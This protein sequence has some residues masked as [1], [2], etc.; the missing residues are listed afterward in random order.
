MIQ[1]LLQT[2]RS[3]LW[4]RRALR[5][6]ALSALLYRAVVAAAQDPKPDIAPIYSYHFNTWEYYEHVYRWQADN[7][8]KIKDTVWLPNVADPLDLTVIYDPYA[9]RGTARSL[10]PTATPTPQPTHVQMLPP[11]FERLF[12][13]SPN[14]RFDLYTVK[15]VQNDENYS[16]YPYTYYVVGIVDRQTGKFI[17]LPETYFGGFYD[18]Q[19]SANNGAFVMTFVGSY[20]GGLYYYYVGGF[21]D[22]VSNARSIPFSPWDRIS[23]IFQ[24]S[25]YQFYDIDNTGRYVLV[26]GYLYAERDAPG[27]MRLLLIDMENLTYEVVSKNN[28]FSAARFL[29]PDN[30]HI[31]YVSDRG[32]FA[33]DREDKTRDT[34][35]KGLNANDTVS[36]EYRVYAPSFSPDGR[37]LVTQIHGEEERQN[38]YVYPI[39]PI[40]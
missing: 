40:P 9:P 21:G 19:W 7:T 18:I 23:E 3:V 14:G 13:T 32:T 4:N 38:L 20:G 22:D 24:W 15:Y 34:L 35:T 8:L 10:L 11:N 17:T 31:V 39:P 33:Y 26:D 30:R 29:Q 2:M 37:Y 1:R 36:S 6:M 28:Y 27:E 5:W 25:P 16:N 12:A